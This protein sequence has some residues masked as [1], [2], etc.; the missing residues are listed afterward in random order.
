MTAARLRRGWPC[1]PS[2][3]LPPGRW[4]AHTAFMAP[5][6]RKKYI[7]RRKKLC[8]ER[9]LSRKKTRSRSTIRRWRSWPRRNWNSLPPMFPRRKRLRPP[10]ARRPRRPRVR[11]SPR[12]IRPQ[13]AWTRGRVRKRP[14]RLIRRPRKGLWT[15]RRSPPP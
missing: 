5:T 4:T 2:T 6:G 11:I 1:R 15:C 12:L 14:A 13:R 9:K 3:S 10:P 7:I 8:P